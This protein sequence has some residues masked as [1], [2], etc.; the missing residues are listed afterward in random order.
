MENKK[1]STLSTEHQTIF[2]HF[3]PHLS[4]R[5]RYLN[6]FS[7]SSELLVYGA[8]T[9]F[10]VYGAAVYLGLVAFSLMLGWASVSLL[11]L[12]LFVLI[13]SRFCKVCFVDRFRSQILAE[14][15]MEM[16]FKAY[17]EISK[18]TDSLRADLL[19]INGLY[20]Q[21]KKRG[22]EYVVLAQEVIDWIKDAEFLLSDDSIRVVKDCILQQRDLSDSK[23]VVID[24]KAKLK[25]EIQ[26]YLKRFFYPGSADDAKKKERQLQS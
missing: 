24:K 23:M 10:S 3:Y 22:D 19:E 15:H 25:D 9:L 5:E 18:D 4:R 1:Y 6:L 13:V 14:S 7:E 8:T 11:T 26:S 16:M 17:D 21:L 12:G 20:T 2:D